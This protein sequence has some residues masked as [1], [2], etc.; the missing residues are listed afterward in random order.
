MGV[1]EGL[2]LGEAQ[3]KGPRGPRGSPCSCCRDRG[4][5][6]V[7]RRTPSFPSRERHYAVRRKKWAGR[8]R[9]CVAPGGAPGGAPETSRSSSR[10]SSIEPAS[11]LM[12]TLLHK[13]EALDLK[14]VSE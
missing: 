5:T 6:T 14:D 9:G 12:E 4:L 7:R 2:A 1:D 8:Q 13:L 10:A 3:D 11:P